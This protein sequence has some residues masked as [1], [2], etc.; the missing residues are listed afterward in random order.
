LFRIGPT[1]P[2][3]RE[4][5]FDR[6]LIL[7]NE[8]QLVLFGVV[9]YETVFGPKEFETQFCYL[10]HLGSG[11]VINWTTADRHNGAT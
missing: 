4:A 10:G 8:K 5:G 9:T 2:P 3:G 7:G 1:A 11:G 6:Q